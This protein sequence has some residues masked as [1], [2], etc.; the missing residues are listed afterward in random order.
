M[1]PRGE[2]AR[3]AQ[4]VSLLRCGAA[5]AAA[6]YARPAGGA[7]VAPRARRRASRNVMLAKTPA[8]P[9]KTPA[10]PLTAKTPAAAQTG[11]TPAAGKT[12]GKPGSAASTFDKV[13]PTVK[14]ALHRVR[15]G[16]RRRASTWEAEARKLCGRRPAPPPSCALSTA[17]PQAAPRPTRTM[18]P[19]PRSPRRSTSTRHSRSC[20]PRA[21]RHRRP[22]PPSARASRGGAACCTASIA[23]TATNTSRKVRRSCRRP[24][25]RPRRRPRPLRR[26]RAHRHAR[27]R[28]ATRDA[29]AARLALIAAAHL[30][31]AAAATHQKLR[32]GDVPE[33][34]AA[35]AVAEGWVTD[36]AVRLRRAAAV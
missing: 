26:R 3:A 20:A 22:N 6:V 8:K 28:G 25:R 17:R 19:P 2:R 9:A 24:P 13:W 23:T 1:R 30:P 16:R 14:E 10:K 36:V 32:F 31:P 29:S 35:A 5:D 21:R 33:K 34:G 18:Q 7:A 11:K 12:P 15:S 27:G 4:A